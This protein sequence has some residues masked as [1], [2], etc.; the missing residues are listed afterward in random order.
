MDLKFTV[1]ARI[2]KPVSA[3][4]EAIVDP[5]QLSKYFT[6]G[7]AKGRLA[8][9]T[10]V[11]WDFHDFPRAFPVEVV[12]VEDNR[13]I[14]LRWE[15]N[16][17]PPDAISGGTSASPGYKTTVTITFEPL[18]EDRSL[19]SITEEGWRETAGG[20][21]ASY[22]NCMGWSQMLCALRV[23]IEHGINLREGMYK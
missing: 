3:V 5:E 17:G 2:S 10:T 1:S 13:M 21:Q 4:F 14:V 15:A 20:L 12:E 16:E 18:D 22:S 11:S 8:T 9:G 19:V 6:T 7:G 23:W